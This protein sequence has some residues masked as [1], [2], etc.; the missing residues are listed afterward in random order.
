MRDPGEFVAALPSLLGFHPRG[1]L[2][3]ASMSGASRRRIGLV[4]RCDLPDPVPELERAVAEH[5]VQALLRD[6]PTSALVAVIDDGGGAGDGGSP[7]RRSLVDAVTDGLRERGVEPRAMVWAA[8]TGDGAPWSCYGPCGCRGTV[9]SSSVSMFAAGASSEGVVVFADRKEL[10]RLVA[11]AD[12]ARLRRRERVLER[13]VDRLAGS[14][15]ALGAPDP[16]TDPAVGTAAVEAALAEAAAGQLTL[17]DGRVVALALA[18]GVTEVRDAAIGIVAAH[19]G[20]GAGVA[21]AE[22]LWAALTRETP[23]PEA[24]EPAALLAVSALLRGD[25]ALANVALDRG[26]RAWPG[27]RLTGLLRQA[28]AM[29]L[30]P[31]EVRAAL[32]RP[33]DE[34][35]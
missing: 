28:V 13:V 33:A 23:D 16:V 32:L 26:E 9:T 6:D 10:E 18:L 24:A 17:D 3:V 20:S 8:G 29:G 4:V 34:P 14:A 12:P 35:S 25:G 22:H 27:H 11:P 1:S 30:R 5:A 21:A 7:P 19:G 31:E 15:G 2:V